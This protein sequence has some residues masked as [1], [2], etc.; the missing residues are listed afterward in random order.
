MHHQWPIYKHN[1]CWRVSSCVIS[2]NCFKECFHKT[3]RFHRAR[4]GSSLQA[5]RYP[6]IHTVHMHQHRSRYSSI[7]NSL[8]VFPSI[9]TIISM[10]KDSPAAIQQSSI[11][12]REGSRPTQRL[13]TSSFRNVQIR[14]IAQRE[15]RLALVD[16]VTGLKVLA[17]I[18]N[19]RSHQNQHRH[20]HCH[21]PLSLSGSL[22]LGAVLI[23]RAILY[24]HILAYK[25]L[26]D[27]M[28][29][30][31]GPLLVIRRSIYKCRPELL[32]LHISNVQETFPNK[33]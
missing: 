9:L 30:G 4:V 18:P 31:R 11:L 13:Q 7:P 28:V 27:R 24:P 33:I 16:L 10:S 6:D 8:K 12:L 1:K 23:R 5:I 14:Y 26:L 15:A 32:P 21:L 3:R 2:W 19:V 20:R 22:H 25:R 17:I 29:N